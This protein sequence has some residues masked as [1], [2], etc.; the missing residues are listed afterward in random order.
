MRHW[1]ADEPLPGLVLCERVLALPSIGDDVGLEVQARAVLGR[2][3]FS[4]GDYA[5]AVAELSKNIA[6]LE[7]KL[8]GE[9]FGSNLLRSVEARWILVWCHAELGEFPQADAR[10]AEAINIAEAAANPHSIIAACV[11]AGN[12]A[13]SRGDVARSIPALEKAMAIVRESNVAVWLPATEA[14][15]AYSYALAGRLSEAMEMAG[16]GFSRRGNIELPR[17]HW[18]GETYLMLRDLDGSR[19]LANRALE[20]S[21]RGGQRGVQA[22]ALRLLGE[23]AGAAKPPDEGAAETQYQEALALAEELGM[24]PLVAHCHLGLGR[25]YRRTGKG[26]QARQHLST[27]TAM[28]R[29]MD[30]QFWLGQAEADQDT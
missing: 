22:W 3:W 18:L 19:A 26:E 25:L 10:A 13:A 11:A 8:E 28:Y 21:T 6:L 30:M 14:L 5:R 15:L 24:R 9:R 2:C 29:E 16:Q 27:A 12:S 23:I 17:I 7:G 1:F 20:G 4:L